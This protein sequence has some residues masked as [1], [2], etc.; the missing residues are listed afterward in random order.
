VRHNSTFVLTEHIA[1]GFE[2]NLPSA[3]R[4]CSRSRDGRCSLKQ[5]FEKNKGVPLHVR[6]W[7]ERSM[8]VAAVFLPLT[9]HE[10]NG[11]QEGHFLLPP[12]S[13]SVSPII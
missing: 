11:D 6:Y 10:A 2:R 9:S 3:E 1:S 4:R 13:M 5:L 8:H 7:E 12:I